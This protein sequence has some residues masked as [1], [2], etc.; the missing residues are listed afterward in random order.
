MFQCRECKLLFTFIFLC[1][2]DKK[3]Y[4]QPM[5]ILSSSLDKTIIIWEPDVSSGVWLES[6][7]VGE[8]GGN[9][10]GFYG[11]KFGPDGQSIMGHGYQGSFHL[12]T[13][14]KVSSTLLLII[15]IQ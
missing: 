4:T 10:L 3:R 11:S 15:C 8:V 1:I 12:W 6:I 9:T 7:R 5:K 14:S 2:E 13:Y